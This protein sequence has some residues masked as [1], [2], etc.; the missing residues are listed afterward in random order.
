M[1]IENRVNLILESAPHRLESEYAVLFTREAKRFIFDLCSE[2]ESKVDEIL[3]KREKRRNE[4]SS[5][6]WKATFCNEKWNNSWKIANIPSY[7]RNRKLDLGDVSPANT[8]HFVDALYA[9]VQGIQVDFDDGHCPTW[10]NTI[11]GLYNVTMAVH[12]LLPNGPANMQKAPVLWL[13]PRAFNMI[14]H[15][16]MVD[17]R[18]VAAPLFDFALLMFHNGKRMHELNIGP[19]FYLS[20]VIF[21]FEV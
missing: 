18:E 4:T 20:K 17:G 19:C 12:A 5:G 3:L 8:T 16:C 15:H 13:R 1:K 11:K 21:D 7:L 10:R 2:F 14:E 6:K 9:D